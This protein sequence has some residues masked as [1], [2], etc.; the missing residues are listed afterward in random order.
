ML[1]CIHRVQRFEEIN[2]FVVDRTHELF[3]WNNG[4]YV[5]VVQ[6]IKNIEPTVVL[7]LVRFYSNL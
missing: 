3:F 5:S 1:Q 6:G 4:L 7:A 2:Y